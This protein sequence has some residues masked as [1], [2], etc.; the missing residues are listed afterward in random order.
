MTTT[1]PVGAADV[2]V[3]AAGAVLWRTGRSG[4]EVGLVHRPRYDDWSFPKGKLDQGESMAAA[5]V[6]EVA[7]ETGHRARLGIRLGDVRYPV[8]EGTKLVRYWAAQER[9]G[10]FVPNDETDELRWVDPGAA[11]VLL[12]YARDHDVLQRFTAT[13][14]PVSVLVLVRHAKAG[15]RQQWD[16]EDALRPLSGSGREQARQLA[17]FL[18]LFGPDRIVSAPPVRCRETVERAAAAV[19]LPVTDEP[20]L[21]ED[22]YWADPAAGLARLRD[23]AARPGVTVVSSQ[24][25]VIPHVLGALVDGRPLGVDPDRV[26]A[27]K[28]STW[29]LTFGVDGPGSADYYPGPTG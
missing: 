9:G 3:L 13:E 17:G 16:G 10:G 22:G 6:R 29:V 27:R 14:L 7:E 2:E 11:A 8:A 24:G 21:G 4:V 5:A 15:S 18:P 26:R 12:S 25:G 20:R 28:A 23:L 19:G 1:R